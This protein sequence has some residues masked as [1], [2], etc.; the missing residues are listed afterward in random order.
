MRFYSLLRH[1]SETGAKEQGGKEENDC[2]KKD[3]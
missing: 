3:F 2:R 1:E